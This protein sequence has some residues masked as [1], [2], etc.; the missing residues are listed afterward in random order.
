MSDLIKSGSYSADAWSFSADESNQLLGDQNWTEYQGWFLGVDASKPNPTLSNTATPTKEWFAYPFGKN[1]LVYLDALKDIASKAMA[2][3]DMDI[4]AMTQDALEDAQELDAQ[5]KVA[6][7]AASEAQFQFD[8]PLKIVASASGKKIPTFTMDAYTGNPMMIKGWAYPIVIDLDGFDPTTKNRPIFLNHDRTQPLGHT[9]AVWIENGTIKASGLISAVGKHVDETIEASVS[10]FPWRASVTTPVQKNQ[11]VPAGQSAQANGQTWNGP[12][13]IAR[14]TSLEEISF[15]PLG[16]DDDTSARIAASAAK[17]TPMTKFEKWAQANKIDLTKLDA[18][19]ITACKATYAVVAGKDDGDETHVEPAK[20]AA[21]QAA[22]AATVGDVIQAA[23]TNAQDKAAVLQEIR[24]A[25]ADERKRMRDLTTRLEKYR[26]RIDGEKYATIE[27][28]A[29]SG[30]LSGDAAELQLIQAARPEPA[31]AAG[32]FFINSGKDSGVN[33]PDGVII[34]AAAAMSIGVGEKSALKGLNERASNLVMGMRGLSLHRLMSISAQSMGMQCPAGGVDQAFLDDFIPRDKASHRRQLSEARQSGVIMASG[35]QGFSTMS[36][37]G[38]TENI[39]FKAMLE[40]YNAFPTTIPDF[41][42]ET[43]TNDFKTYK[44]YR[45]TGVGDL[46]LVGPTGEIKNMS[47]QDES[48]PNQVS[49]KAALMTLTRENLTNDDM[50][51]LTQAPTVAGRKAALNKEKAAYT[52]LLSGLTTV[53]PGPSVGKTANTDFFF[54]A[55]AGNYMTGAASALGIT[56]VT[57]AR[58]KFLQQVDAAGD[59][60]MLMPDRLLV[61]PE[62][63]DAA[64]NLYQG[65]NIVVGALGSTSSKSLDVN[66]NQH[67]GSFK[68]IM[69]PYLGGSSPV[70]GHS[71]TQFLMLPNPAGGMAPVQVG[72]LR[73]QRTPIIRQVETDSNVLG[74]SYQIIYDFGIAL[75]DYRTA[76]YSAGA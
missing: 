15:V 67:K 8:C 35:G 19:K 27:A 17:G 3:G 76:V 25:A 70:T 42:Y 5:K 66:M 28:S 46:Q 74:I 65:A 13:N 43:D 23:A 48:Y 2:A 4:A 50:G 6:S 58:T 44:R 54:S 57:T 24:A 75:H 60:I 37:T 16:G 72:Y 52:T 71:A 30:D 36:L 39:M 18:P 64:N 45:L 12:I 68:P 7:G 40:Q 63:L 32:G 56:A 73:G 10:G 49:T 29:I 51:A 22:A 62:L 21:I 41:C 59:P 53:A 9:T 55:N 26:G 69:S 47:L 1:G 31:N 14:R 11:F 61:P 20:P 33:A 34:A 38:I